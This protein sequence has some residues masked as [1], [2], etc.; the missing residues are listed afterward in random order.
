[1]GFQT[2]EKFCQFHRYR[3]YHAPLLQHR[4]RIFAAA[5]E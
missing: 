1:M 5:F 3:R 4:N 2:Y